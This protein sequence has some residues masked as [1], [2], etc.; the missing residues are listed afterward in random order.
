[1]KTEHKI[2]T[3]SLVFGLLAWVADCAV[4]YFF[5]DE[6]SLWQLFL[7]DTPPHEIY[8]HS[9]IVICFLVF[10]IITARLFSTRLRTKEY[11]ATTLH[12]VGEAVIST[13]TSGIVTFLNHEA[14]RLTGWTLKAAEGRPLGEVLPLVD[15]Q[16][17]E[18][19][20]HPV[21]RVLRSGELA[22]LPHQT[23]LIAKDGTRQPIDGSMAPI[24]DRKRY[25]IG[26]AVTF[27]DI[28]THR[29]VIK[30]LR[31]E[32][33][34]VQQYLHIAGVI[35][36]A[37]DA[38]GKV[39]LINRKGCEVLCAKEEDIIGKN[40]FDDFLPAK[41]RDE[42]KAVFAQLMAGR[43][44]P[45]EHFENTIVSKTGE[46]RLVAWHNTVITDRKGT[47]V[48]TLSSGEDITERRR[49]TAAL[50]E[51]EERFRTIFT[52]AE[53]CIFIKD[54]E[55]KFTH[56]NPSMEKLLGLLAAQMIGRTE[57]DVFGIAGSGHVREVDTRVLAGETIEE[58]ITQRINGVLTTFHV[59]K[60][61]MRH[62]SGAITGIYGI[63][64]NITQ[65]KHSEN[66][67]RESEARL[68]RQNAALAKLDLRKTLVHGDLRVAARKI[69]ETIS[70]T[71]RVERASVWLYDDA[72]SAIRCI[73]LYEQSKQS[74]S[75]GI[76]LEKEKYP[77]YFAALEENRTIAADNAHTD[78]RTREFSG[79]YLAP[80][81]ISSMLDAPI[82]AGDR[83]AGVICCEQVGPARRW[84]LDEE[85]FA[86]SMA[87]SITLALGNTERRRDQEALRE[88]EEKYRDLIERANDGIAI[89]Q[90]TT[91]KYVNPRLAEMIGYPVEELLGTPYTDFI[92]PDQLDEVRRIHAQR[93]A[94]GN[95]PAVY[96]TELRHRSGEKIEVEFNAG[97]MKYQGSPAVLV[98]IRDLSE[99][100]RTEEQIIS[101]ER[102]FKAVFETA[103][104]AIFLMH[105]DTFVDCNLKTEQ[106]FGCPREEILQRKP[107][108]FSPPNQPDGRDSKEKALEK[109][110]AALGGTPQ[111]FEWIHTKLDGSL[112]DAEVSL[113]R[114][115]IDG[116]TM[117]QAIV[118]DITERKATEKMLQ[119]ERDLVTNILDAMKD[120][121][122]IANEKCE[123]EY[124]N[125]ALI[126]QFGPYRGEKC[127]EYFDDRSTPCSWCK[128]ERVFAGKPVQWEWHS[129]KTAKVYDVLNTVLENPDGHQ[130]MLVM[131][132]DISEN[133]ESEKSLRHAQKTLEQIFKESL[134]V[135]MII[136]EDGELLK[137]SHS[138]QDVLGYAAEGLV[139]KNISTLL[140][141]QLTRSQE[142]FLAK[143]RVYGGVFE[144]QHILRR[145]NSIC[146]M[147]LTATLIPWADS[148][149]ILATFRDVSER[150]RAG[151]AT[152]KGGKKA[153]RGS[154]TK[155]VQSLA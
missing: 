141:S 8:F 78:P 53:D 137:V 40:W 123:I 116:R 52:A 88:S 140:P 82:R 36:V 155:K 13:D 32:K 124:I 43:V 9:L 56:V 79:S 85:N 23:I 96:E 67:L 146:L 112:F 127:H 118:R 44:E 39:T 125:P 62:S 77:A 4:S 91:L 15:E 55:L 71:L 102:K 17:G 117:L 18:Q 87:D 49:A 12:S 139:G 28:T 150:K 41:V 21:E 99:R 133:R 68:Q 129:S 108:E 113:N 90:D 93:M 20:A 6:G 128:M 154:E 149:A 110:T 38:Q 10:G 109:I 25:T 61:P 92:W 73:D 104:D 63:A 100:R 130:S 69:T 60:I 16:T 33:D 138:T 134:D 11:L 121:I 114:V 105:E 2:L 80:L 74:H 45:V 76:E 34:T 54:R 70:E 103:N 126:D 151:K 7:L 144:E 136:G 86:A 94:G 46:E 142:E 119:K 50:Q 152:A 120:G 5:F 65:R 27:H 107:Y 83:I 59:I 64:R 24:K 106:I 147:D 81:G 58:E 132:H 95:A 84:M 35:I 51:S 19:T 75:D 145:D 111:R 72:R 101:S 115:E 66:I 30:A 98:F 47:I 26:V 37:L 89:V 135:I 1:L 143:L 48:G 42:V 97:V 153:R 3:Y 122:Y 131:L 14:Q 31:E 57:E 22:G 148:K 29:K